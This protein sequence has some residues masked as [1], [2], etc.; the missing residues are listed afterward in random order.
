MLIRERERERESRRAL[1][2]SQIG[3]LGDSTREVSM[4]SC[5][6]ER[7]VQDAELRTSKDAKR[8]VVNVEYQNVEWQT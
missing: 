4:R 8:R 3:I 5:T 6:G 2:W 7:L 1:E